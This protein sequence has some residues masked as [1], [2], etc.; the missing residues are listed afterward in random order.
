MIA[1]KIDQE[2]CPIGDALIATRDTCLGHE[3]CE[4]LWTIKST[5]IDM[6]LAGAEIIVN[7]SGSYM[8]LRKAHVV[9]DLVKSASAKAGGA[10]LYSNVRGCDGQRVWFNGCSSVALNGEFIARGKQFSLQDVVRTNPYF[11]LKQ[12]KMEN[13]QDNKINIQEKKTNQK[14]ELR[15][16][17]EIMCMFN[18]P[19]L[20]CK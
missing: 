8:E 17:I 16:L 9:T 13:L 1:R 12:K 19:I 2:T 10:Y 18:L 14:R 15:N 4:E 5:H 20:S 3:I 6:S 11:Y 7:G